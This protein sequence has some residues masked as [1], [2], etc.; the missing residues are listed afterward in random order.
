MCKTT[1][2]ENNM[3]RVHE[4]EKFGW[5]GPFHFITVIQLPSPSLAASNSA[6]YQ[7][8]CRDVYQ[9]CKGFGV[10]VGVC[11]VCGM[12][13]MNNYVCRDA[14][15]KHFVIGCDCAK[16][17]GDTKLM[18]KIDAAEAKRV[19]EA[20]E[21]KRVKAAD[22]RRAAEQAKLDAERAV[23]GGLTNRE[24]AERN[25]ELAERAELE[26]NR[27]IYI[28]KN[29]WLLT[30]LRAGN[31]PVGGFVSN[32]VERLESSPVSKL[33]PRA[34]EIVREIYAKSFG[35]VNSKANNAA[36]DEFDRL[37]GLEQGGAE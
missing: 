3:V 25:Q 16:K 8:A 34:L 6:A 10:S 22:E 37:A 20:R 5:V 19:R 18:T 32:M 30:V 36:C 17:L 27:Q 29:K 13:L 23:N 4:W 12:A 9:S 28:V 24:L 14:V 31:H 15:G 35:R 7:N 26:S 2:A 11:E 1:V 33:S 21:A